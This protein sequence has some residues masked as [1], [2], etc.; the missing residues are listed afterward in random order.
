MVGSPGE[1]EA[2]CARGARALGAGRGGPLCP[3]YAALPAG[4]GGGRRPA[5]SGPFP[6]RTPRALGVLGRASRPLLHQPCRQALLTT[7]GLGFGV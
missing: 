4:R 7:E 2:T 5:A 3:L 1:L 6:A